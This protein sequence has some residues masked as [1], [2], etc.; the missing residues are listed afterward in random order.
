MHKYLNSITPIRFAHYV[1]VFQ[2]AEVSKEYPLEV[3]QMTMRDLLEQKKRLIGFKRTLDK[4][5]PVTSWEGMTYA[6]T[7]VQLV[8][9]ELKLEEIEKDR[10]AMRS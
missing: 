4:D 3:M 6:R 1:S 9:I 2:S 8:L 10:T 5:A 7:L